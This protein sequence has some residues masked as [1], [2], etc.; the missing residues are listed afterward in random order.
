MHHSYDLYTWEDQE[1]SQQHCDLHE[2]WQSSFQGMEN[3][4]AMHSARF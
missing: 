2:S 4:P 3:F 1:L